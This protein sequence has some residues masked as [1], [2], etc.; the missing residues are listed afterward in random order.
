MHVF[1]ANVGTGLFM[2][3]T[4]YPDAGYIL[5]PMLMIGIGLV[6]IDCTHLL[7][8]TKIAINRRN[9][10]SYSNICRFVYGAPM[11]W[12]LFVSLCLTQFGFCLMYSQLASYTMDQ[13]V[14]FKHGTKVWAV[15]IFCICLPI[16]CYSNNLSLLAIFSII[17][18]VSIFYAL[19]CCF[20]Q[21]VITLCGHHGNKH[22][23]CVSAGRKY[24]FGWFNNLANDMMVL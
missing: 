15:C 6:V 18:T 23:T 11:Q 17:A 2:L 22:P 24:P 21:S 7:L 16:T 19:L 12:F 14:P 10:T 4:F 8:N 3:P 9:V 13:L 20:I 1:K 5:S